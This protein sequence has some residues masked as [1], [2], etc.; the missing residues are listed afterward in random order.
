MLPD[1]PQSTPEYGRA[2]T[3]G[4]IFSKPTT[5]ESAYSSQQHRYFI[6]CPASSDDIVIGMLLSPSPRA[7][8]PQ[9]WAAYLHL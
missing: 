6:M 1:H 4:S 5:Q 8:L 9:S 3:T 2:H 7:F